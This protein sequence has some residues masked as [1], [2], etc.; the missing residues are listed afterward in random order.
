VSEVNSPRSIKDRY[1]DDLVPSIFFCR[2]HIPEYGNNKPIVVCD[3]V[4]TCP[5]R[6]L[7]QKR[8]DVLKVDMWIISNGP[9][10]LL[11]V[12]V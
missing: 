3:E 7:I 9:I 2:N 11:L 8:M 10:D 5:S 12:C 6:P 4:C 1:I